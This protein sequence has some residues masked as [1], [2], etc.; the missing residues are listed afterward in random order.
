LISGPEVLSKWLGESEANL[1]KLFARARQLAPSVVLLDELDSLAPRRDR[2]SQHHDVQILS[3]LLVLLDGLEARGAV[4]LVATSNR[5][6]AIDPALCRPGRFDYH[7]E[8]PMPDYPGRLA[9]LQVCLAKMKTRGALA[10]EALAEATAGYS[11]AELAALCREAGL[12]AIRR[13]LACGLA[14][15]QLVVCRQDLHQALGALRAKRCHPTQLH[16]GLPN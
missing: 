9:I 1:R 13:A 6:E 5:L 15:D 4:A 2:V 8:V 7:I 3:Q 10:I 16:R 14:A 12:Q 11:G